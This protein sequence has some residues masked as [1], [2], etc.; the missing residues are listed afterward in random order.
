MFM[1][2]SRIERQQW[3]FALTR[4]QQWAHMRRHLGISMNKCPVCVKSKTHFRV[5]VSPQEGALHPSK[6]WSAHACSLSRLSLY[7]SVPWWLS[8]RRL[9]CLIPVKCRSRGY[10][11]GSHVPRSEWMEHSNRVSLVGKT[12]GWARH[13]ANRLNSDITTRVWSRCLMLSSLGVGV[14]CCLSVDCNFSFTVIMCVSLFLSCEHPVGNF[15]VLFVL[16]G[17]WYQTL[18]TVTL[19]ELI[20]GDASAEL[21]PLNLLNGGRRV[22]FLH[23]WPFRGSISTIRRPSF[24]SSDC[25]FSRQSP[26]NIV[27]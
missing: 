24:H 19:A 6:Q 14:W 16:D 17:R 15:R 3:G 8:W 26:Q 1:S 23:L 9:M 2:L 21:K 5:S 25:L 27:L 22:T 11:S 10:H 18:R 20:L 12:D 7:T 13:L 4:R